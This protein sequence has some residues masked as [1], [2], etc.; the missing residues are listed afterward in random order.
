M[1]PSTL[2]SLSGVQIDA[3]PATTTAEIRTPAP[4]CPASAPASGW[5]YAAW[6]T[7]IVFGGLAW[8]SIVLWRDRR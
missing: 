2:P 1:I 8:M 5:P 6:V 4:A 7:L 3:L